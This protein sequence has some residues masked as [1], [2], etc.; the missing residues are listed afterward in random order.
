MADLFVSLLVIL[1]IIVYV[2]SKASKKPLSEV[3]ESIIDKL[4][5]REYTTEDSG[6]F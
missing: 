6:V 1:A 3:F 5:P 4:K 2:Y